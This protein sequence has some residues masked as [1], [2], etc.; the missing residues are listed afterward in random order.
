MKCPFCNENLTEGDL[1]C[2]NC[3]D[4]AIDFDYLEN[5]DRMEEKYCKTSLRDLSQ[6]KLT[7]EEIVT[8]YTFIERAD[9]HGGD[10]DIWDECTED[11]TFSNLTRQ[12]K[13]MR[14]SG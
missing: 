14:N 5:M 6:E 1:R 9:H 13:E 4:L 7:F 12:L 2:P 11:G 8:I 3:R 10:D